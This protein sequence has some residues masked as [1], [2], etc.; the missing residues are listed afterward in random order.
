MWYQNKYIIMSHIL[1]NGYI[2]VRFMFLFVFYRESNV[3]GV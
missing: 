3:V 1:C 2:M